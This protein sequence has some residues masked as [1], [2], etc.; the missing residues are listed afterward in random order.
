VEILQPLEQ[1]GEP[2]PVISHQAAPEEREP[3]FKHIFKGGVSDPDPV[4]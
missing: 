4:G 1:K 2:L 3:K